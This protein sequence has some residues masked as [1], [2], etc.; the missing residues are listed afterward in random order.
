M[1]NHTRSV[2]IALLLALVICPLAGARAETA[3]QPWP[4]NGVIYQSSAYTAQEAELDVTLRNLQAGSAALVKLYTANGDL[5]CCLF[6]GQTGTA[7]NSLQITAQ[8]PGGKYT[9]TL[10]IGQS[11]YGLNAAFGADGTYTSLSLSDDSTVTTLDAGC[12]YTLYID[13][14][15]EAGSAAIPYSEF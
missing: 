8:L 1:K 12:T 14:S 11:W 10:G 13:S 2:W 7:G 5:V 3:A 6:A 15:P 4:A 9:L